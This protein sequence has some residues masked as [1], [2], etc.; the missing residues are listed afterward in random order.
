LA[1]GGNGDSAALLNEQ[2]DLMRR[3]IDR[4]LARA[5]TV[6]ATAAGG[7]LTDAHKTVARLIDLVGRM[8]RADAI[9]WENQVDEGLRLRMDPD[10]FGE[11]MGNLLDNARKWATSNVRVGAEVLG[12]VASI[13]VDDDGPGPAAADLARLPL[14]GERANADGEGAGLGL[15]IVSDVLSQYHSALTIEAS[16][17]GGCRAKFSAPA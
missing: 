1:S 3:H 10:D 14:R 13:V 6:G 11:I 4:E 5:R 12:G 17:Q 16:P 8:P 7:T 2:V 9:A 15:A